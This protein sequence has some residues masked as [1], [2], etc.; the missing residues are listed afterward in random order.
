MKEL[1]FFCTLAAGDIGTTRAVLNQRGYELNPL[2]RGGLKEQVLF[3]SAVCLAQSVITNKSKK[4]R[5]LY[6]IGGIIGAGLIGNNTYQLMKIK[7]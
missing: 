5:T 6:I 3:K 1:L 7:H 2:M 4:K